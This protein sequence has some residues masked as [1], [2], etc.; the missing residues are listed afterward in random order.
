M[1]RF[2]EI[3]V[4]EAITAIETVSPP[5]WDASRG[6]YFTEGRTVRPLVP[7]RASFAILPDGTATVGA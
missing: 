4:D 1:P 5:L 6:G 7:G 2:R 3:E